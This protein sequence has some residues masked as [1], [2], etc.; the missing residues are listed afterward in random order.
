[1]FGDNWL[2]EVPWIF[3]EMRFYPYSHGEEHGPVGWGL[4]EPQK[5]N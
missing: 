1:M 5:F 3:S 2:K 4:E